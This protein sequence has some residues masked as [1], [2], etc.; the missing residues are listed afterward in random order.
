M[1]TMVS[2]L[3]KPSLEMTPVRRSAIS[4]ALSEEVGTTGSDVAGAVAAEMGAKDSLTYDDLLRA[5][6][7]LVHP[8]LAVVVG[9]VFHQPV[10]G[11]VGVGA[12]VDLVLT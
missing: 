9:H 11:V 8:D 4:S 6:V 3:P 10:D 2:T 5:R 12:F 1:P 7:D